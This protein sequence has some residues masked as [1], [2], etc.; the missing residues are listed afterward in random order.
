MDIELILS[1]Y[2]DNYN[3]SSMVPGPRNMY[4]G[5]IATPKR[6]LVDG[7]GS[8]GGGVSYPT[9]SYILKKLEKG[10]DIGEI[11]R[12]FAKDNN[13]NIFGGT[14]TK[15]PK[16]R[17]N[18]NAAVRRKIYGENRMLPD[19]E[20]VSLLENNIKNSNPEV[21]QKQFTNF[22]NEN[23]SKYLNKKGGTEKLY[24][25]A[26]KWFKKNNPA[27]LLTYDGTQVRALRPGQEIIRLKSGEGSIETSYKRGRQEIREIVSPSKGVGPVKSINKY[28][29]LDEAWGMA[30]DSLKMSTKD[31]KNM[32]QNY[33]TRPTQRIIPGLTGTKY[34]AGPEHVYGL[35][36]AIGTSLK[37]E[38]IK[39]ATNVS[40]AP[41]EFNSLIKGPLLDKKV[42]GMI[43]NAFNTNDIS[44]RKKIIE[45]ANN[46]INLFAKKYPGTYPKYVVDKVGNIKDVNLKK[47]NL[48]AKTAV[49]LGGE[50]ID[51]LL[52]TP[53]FTA[54][55][56]YKRLPEE[57]KNLINV[58]KSGDVNEFKTLLASIS[59]NPKC[60][61]GFFSGG[62]VGFKDGSVSLDQCAWDGAKVVNSGKFKSGAEARNAAKFLNAAM[63]IG[64]KAYKG[65]RWISKYGVIP[66][67]LFV[68]G[69]SLVRMGMGDNLD[70]AFLRATDY[71]R[72]GDQT[73]E[74]NLK[75]LT[76][77]IGPENAQTV[78]RA[79]D[80][81]ESLQ[82]LNDAKSSLEQN[83]MVL[84]DSEF[85]YM[86]NIDSREILARDEKKVQ[87]AE[88]DMKAKFQPEAVMDYATMQESEAEDIR[89]S[90]SK[91]RE[92]IETA[93]Q[94]EVDDF[95]QVAT[96]EK[97]KRAAD[98]MFTMD[99]LAD[100][101]I[102]D[103]FLKSEQDIMGAP[104]L[105]KRNLFDYHRGDED[106]NKAVW[107]A[108]MEGGRSNLANRERLFGTQG[109]FGGQPLANGGI[110][111]LTRTTPHESE[112]GITSLNVKKK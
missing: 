101:W 5:G 109:T 43:D 33:I 56:E 17:R 92:F 35:R 107:K 47:I 16:A 8:Y 110:A 88:A 86:A 27:G 81:K 14:R 104:E 50:Y 34:A 19:K 44:K 89:K 85:G 11:V 83:Q 76:R 87:E 38:L 66:E 75:M 41:R 93:R 69:E 31:Y 94:N 60:K 63:N 67:A 61:A 57:S 112:G 24:E 2:E 70:E 52:K 53:G 3:P 10:Y 95:E 79:N 54:S 72:P 90:N 105:K 111:S 82:R 59:R 49:D 26:V 98:P 103:E 99:D 22:V 23:K 102:P 48:K 21:V 6:G 84:D 46:E 51:Y 68:A 15:V 18:L 77:T 71:L 106:F 64:N 12:D 65:L 78:L 91:I 42:T 25:D 30:A 74:A 73:K 9:R 45:S 28:K 39:S 96:P 80:Y 36:Q 100:Y 4:A 108:V 97:V 13:I 29:R 1:M 58:R 37:K 62:R 55:K 32:L 20:L 7:P 40:P